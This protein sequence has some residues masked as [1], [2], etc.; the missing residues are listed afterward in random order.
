MKRHLTKIILALPVAIAFIVASWLQAQEP[1][2]GEGPPATQQ[3][4]PAAARISLIDGQASIQRG[5]TGEWVTATVNTP[6]VAGDVIATGP[7]SRAEVELDYANVVRLDQNSQ[8]K[9]A[10]LSQGRVQVQVGQGLADYVVLRGNQDNIEIDTPNVAIQP[11][12]EGTYRIEVNSASEA[13]LTVR[14]GEAQVSTAQGST[15]VKQGETITIQGT[16]NPEYQITQAAGLDEWDG[17]NERRDQQILQAQSWN[18]TDQY[19]TGS[20]NLDQYGHWEDV[21]G[22]GDSWTPYAGPGWA[23]YAD[24]SW[25]WEPYY[26]WTWV[27]YEPWG[28]APY[29]Y[30]RWF[31]RNSS[32]FWWPGPVG[33]GFGLYRP[34]WAP[35][36]VSFFGFGA[37]G[38]GFGFGFGS[39]GWLPIGPRDPFFPWWGFRG[40]GRGFNVINVTNIRNI[41]NIRNF[42]GAGVMAPL[43][44]GNRP[45]FGSNLE[46][47]FSDPVVRNAITT[48]AGSRFG[49][50]PVQPLHQAISA[51][52]LRG[53]QL[54]AGRLPV[55]PTRAS[56]AATNRPVAGNAIPR[57]GST[58]TRFFSRQQPSTG[59][60]S[61]AQEASSVRQMVQ[62]LKPGNVA[63]Q[64]RALA[65]EIDRAGSSPQA[66]SRGSA[67][68]QGERLGRQQFGSASNGATNSGRIID[69]DTLARMYGRQGTNQ[70]RPPAAGAGS[71]TSGWRRFAGGASSTTPGQARS[72]PGSGASPSFR[73]GNESR[74]DWNHF[75]GQSQAPRQNAFGNRSPGTFPNRGSF[76]SPPVPE[77]TFGGRPAPRQYSA[78]YS[79]G[80]SRPPL[81]LSRP[82][83]SQRAPSYSRSYGYGSRGYSHDGYS[84]GGAR[85]SGGRH[86]SSGSH[87]SGSR[88]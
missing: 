73:G 87:G 79:Y 16:D 23:P 29:H 43:A 51:A 67:A 74:P 68:A 56:L 50:G 47:A 38:F 19:Y 30:G 77:S 46:R 45:N 3:S 70:G 49:Q 42:N 58:A 24:G 22:Y 13:R 27:S 33:F 83:F 26:G 60:R 54:V 52:A 81:Q 14:G 71:D 85:S 2:A 35:A 37:G 32:W 80:Y 86:S 76:A 21:P 10:D 11:G 59:V 62:G 36:Y 9:V 78:P 65:Q 88:H 64:G 66:A 20:E 4:A 48:V 53:S 84:G 69:N 15:T 25:V 57:A 55:V 6:L 63:E 18:H 40:F 39:I 1:P 7:S 31:L 72:A 82:M 44:G 34:I 17:W 12:A 41:T 75:A 8:V 28:W 5:D 61:F